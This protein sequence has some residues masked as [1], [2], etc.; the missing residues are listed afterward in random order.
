MQREERRERRELVRE[1]SEDR[2][3]TIAVNGERKEERR[4]ERKD[5][6]EERKKDEREK[7]EKRGGQIVKREERREM[8]GERT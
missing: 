3:G 2:E 4:H 7:T 8:R 1:R 6:R 5:I